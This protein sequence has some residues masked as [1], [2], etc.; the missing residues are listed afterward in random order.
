M[1][2]PAISAIKKAGYR[3]ACSTN[4]DAVNI[5][6]NQ[7]ALN[8][9]EIEPGDDLGRFKGKISHRHNYRFYKQKV[10]N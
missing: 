4:W 3:A 8:R 9:L 10:K 2:D 6:A 5:K 7:F 1:D